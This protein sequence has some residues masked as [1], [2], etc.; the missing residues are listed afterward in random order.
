MSDT[1]SPGFDALIESVMGRYDE[2]VRR[3]TTDSYDALRAVAFDRDGLGGVPGEI[4]DIAESVG[5]PLDD[6]SFLEALWAAAERY[7]AKLR[8]E[9]TTRTTTTTIAATDAELNAAEAIAADVR[10]SGAVDFAAFHDISDANTILHEHMATQGLDAL[11]DHSAANRVTATVDLL[12]APDL[13]TLDDDGNPLRCGDCGRRM[14]YD[15]Q[16]EAYR[17]LLDPERACFLIHAETQAD[18]DAEARND[19]VTT[20]L[21]RL[22]QPTTDSQEP[23]PPGATGIDR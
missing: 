12:L 3:N 10:E 17:H 8:D 2:A 7:Q 1:G 23:E 22:E 21:D 11:A 5:A 18:L 13:A 16:R 15:Y 14:A 19:A 4:V 20:R 6:R 9:L